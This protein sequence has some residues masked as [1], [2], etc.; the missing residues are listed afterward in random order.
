MTKIIGK[1]SSLFWEILKS[2]IIAL[3]I[4][5]PI[6]YFLF[7]PFLVRGASM[8]PNFY[9][10][11]YLIVDMISYRFREPLRG[12]V[13]VFRAPNRP[14][15]KFIKRIIGL[16]GETVKIRDGEVLIYLDQ[17]YYLVLN[18]LD[19][20]RPQTKTAGNL[21][22]IL[23]EDEYFVLGDN[24]MASSDSRHWGILPKEKIIG[25]TMIRIWPFDAMTKIRIPEYLLGINVKNVN[26]IGK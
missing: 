8:E 23:G 7:Q 21:R 14:L 17:D 25:R 24:R 13:I 9:N 16:P 19:Y 6:R 12:E 20:L 15:Q 18:E 2:I 3:I 5:V 22:I 26:N 10:N 1:S 11:D 4:V